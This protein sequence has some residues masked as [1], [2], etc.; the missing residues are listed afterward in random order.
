MSDHLG[1]KA[2]APEGSSRRSGLRPPETGLAETM[3]H[4]PDSSTSLSSDQR[5]STLAA[6]KRAR[7]GAFRDFESFSS[8][9]NSAFDKEFQPKSLM[10]KLAVH[11]PCKQGIYGKGKPFRLSRAL[12]ACEQARGPDADRRTTI[13]ILLEAEGSSSGACS[14]ATALD[15]ARCLS[16]CRAG[17][18]SIL[19]L[20]ILLAGE[21]CRAMRLIC[22]PS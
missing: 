15:V 19:A 13:L 7:C 18:T 20:E 12:E 10:A 2:V 4:L 3:S 14:Q 11:F 16:M 1:R 6:R 17:A 8:L 22:R 5:L 9:H 21:P